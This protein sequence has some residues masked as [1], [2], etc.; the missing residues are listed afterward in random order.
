MP[1]DLGPIDTTTLSNL[2]IIIDMNSFEF[3]YT[4]NEIQELTN[5]YANVLMAVMMDIL[6]A[7]I[8][9]VLVEIGLG[10]LIVFMSRKMYKRI[11][12]R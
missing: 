4:T 5:S 6:G 7:I 2:G 9:I 1:V 12:M 11:L 3:Q 10:I 8:L